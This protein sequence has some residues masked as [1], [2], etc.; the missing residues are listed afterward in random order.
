[1]K[2]SLKKNHHKNINY[3]VEFVLFCMQAHHN[4]STYS[5]CDI[6]VKENIVH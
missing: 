6:Y 1:M 2:V 4:Q 3:L 5:V